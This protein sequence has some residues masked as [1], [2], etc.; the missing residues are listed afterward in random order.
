MNNIPEPAYHFCWFPAFNPYIYKIVCWE[1]AK[2][3]L[4]LVPCIQI[5]ALQ[6]HVPGTSKAY[7]VTGSL[8]SMIAL[9]DQ[10]SGTSK[11]YIVTGSLHFLQWFTEK[12]L[13]AKIRKYPGNQQSKQP[14]LVLPSMDRT[15]HYKAKWVA[16]N[17]LNLKH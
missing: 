16:E 4:S 3:T 13:T 8:H 10:V 14:R 5:F 17:G 15:I 12:Q 9:Q 2:H 7:I 1:P 6:D 11:A